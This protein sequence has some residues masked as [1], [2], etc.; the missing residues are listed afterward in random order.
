MSGRVDTVCFDKTGT[1]TYQ[2]MN[3]R[4]IVIDNKLIQECDEEKFGDGFD[5]MLCCQSL[6]KM[7]K[8]I[9][10][11]VKNELNSKSIMTEEKD[12]EIKILGDPMEQK[13]MEYVNGELDEEDNQES[14]Y[15]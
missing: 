7:R 15:I 11:K 3:V 10:R 1:L 6:A 2:G 9:E 4:G 14:I 13:L 5:C 8:E 12:F